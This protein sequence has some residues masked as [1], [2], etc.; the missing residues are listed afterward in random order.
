MLY[1]ARTGGFYTAQIHLSS[2]P[3]DAV[4]ITDE[5][6]RALLDGQSAGKLIVADD[7]GH[8]V[9]RDPPKPAL[10]V[11]Q[12]A[13]WEAIK[14][15]RDRRTQQ[16]GYKVGPHW[17]HSDTFSRTQQL[18]LVMMGANMPPGVKWKTL[19]GDMVDMTPAL[20][21]AIFAAAAASD[22]TIYAAAEAHRLAMLASETPETYDFTG[23]WPA[24]FEG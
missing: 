5:E 19:S 6:H 20:A 3:P 11:R 7:T 1:S 9:L 12:A 14:T 18:G 16:G 13:A 23:G 24:S 4:E 8:P 10:E 17:F 15:E 21:Q 2:I 22:V